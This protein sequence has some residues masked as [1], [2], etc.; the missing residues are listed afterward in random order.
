MSEGGWPD[1]SRACGARQCSLKRPV[2]SSVSFLPAH[3]PR[4]GVRRKLGEGIGFLARARVLG[5]A[6]SSSTSNCGCF[7]KVR[8]TSL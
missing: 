3:H 8:G 6:P 7:E 1:A 5:V 2:S 4:H